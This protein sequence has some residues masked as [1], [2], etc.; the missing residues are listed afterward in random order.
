MSAV[1]SSSL[2]FVAVVC[3]VM[4]AACD[5]IEDPV[6][7]VTSNYLEAVYGPAPEFDALPLSSAEKRVVVEDFTAH[8]CGNC[9]AAAIIAEDIAATH[10]GLVS[11]MAIHAGDLA[12]T[13][14]EYFDTDWTTE[15]GNIYWD[16]LDF[17][18]NPLGRVNRVNGTGAFLAP[19]QWN[20]I[21]TSEL[22]KDIS[23]GLQMVQ[24]WEPV[25]RHLNLHLHG[26]FY[27][28]LAGP[29]Q[30][31]WLILESNIIDYQLDYASEPAVVA[32]YEF[33][34]V[35]RGSVHGARGLGFGGGA[36]GAAAGDE[37]MQ[38]VT[39]TW[40]ENWI[41]ENATILAVVTDGEGYIL[42][43][44]EIHPGE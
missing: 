16:E 21:V 5:V 1:P 8:Q 19:A 37:A 25:N 32:D 38:S 9:P 23:V 6:I 15:E 26:T 44:L 35:L 31:A 27:E 24:S 11:V 33:D 43:S 28:N 10:E 3:L 17:Q 40:D 42:N 18:A 20:D 2:Q 30:V 22:E 39:L 4:L 41:L 12:T 34:H 29:I 36:D 7:P 14:D 13:D